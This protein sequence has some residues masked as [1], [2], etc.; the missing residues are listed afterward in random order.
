MGDGRLSV[1][2]LHMFTQA[3]FEAANEVLLSP[4]NLGMLDMPRSW[5]NLLRK[6]LGGGGEVLAN[7]PTRVTFQPLG[8]SGWFVQ[9]YN[10]EVATVE[11][12]GRADRSLRDGF[13]GEPIPSE[14]GRIVC[15][16]PARSRLWLAFTD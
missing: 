2:N 6:Q 13:S 11:V 8:D 3:D 15:E 5:A 10:N 14:G 1:W 16:I 4:R 7:A 9:N 12:R